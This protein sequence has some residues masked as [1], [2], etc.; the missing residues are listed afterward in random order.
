MSLPD[1]F[2]HFSDI[3][4]MMTTWPVPS[5]TSV[6]LRQNHRLWKI[7][8]LWLKTTLKTCIQATQKTYPKTTQF[9]SLFS[10]PNPP[11]IV[12][13]LRRGDDFWKLHWKT[14]LFGVPDL[15]TFLP[16]KSSFV[17]MPQ[18]AWSSENHIF[19]NE[20][21]GISFFKTKTRSGK[22][23]QKMTQQKL[24]KSI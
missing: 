10:V 3:L 18:H 15:T 4:H 17:N 22:N 12:L 14:H 20:F 11:K 5:K 9:F 16:Q 8:M 1:A 23:T 2:F 7:I 21:Q 13:L 6:L 19:C 24:N